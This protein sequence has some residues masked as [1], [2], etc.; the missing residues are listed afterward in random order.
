MTAIEN[1]QV[2]MHSRL[3]SRFTGMVLRTPFNRREEKDVATSRR[4]SC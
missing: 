1:V 3:R 2:G 4:A